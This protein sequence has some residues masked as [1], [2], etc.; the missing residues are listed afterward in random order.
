MVVLV[1][2]ILS[3]ILLIAI[4]IV[5]RFANNSRPYNFPIYFNWCI[6]WKVNEFKK[7]NVT[8]CVYICYQRR[9]SK[10]LILK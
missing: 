9:F 4:Y 3:N 1:Y 7:R 8:D 6:N 5:C 2:V 10:M